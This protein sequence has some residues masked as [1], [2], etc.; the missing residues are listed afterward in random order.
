[1]QGIH[2][3]LHKRQP[4]IPRSLAKDQNCRDVEANMPTDVHIPIVVM[5]APIVAVPATECVAW[6]KIAM[7]G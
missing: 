2:T 5:I 3:L 4:G 1:M 6:R 7:N